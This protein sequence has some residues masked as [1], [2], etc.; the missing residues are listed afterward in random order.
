MTPAACLLVLLAAGPDAGVAG[1]VPLSPYEVEIS[2]AVA[3]V[4][5]VWPLP[6]ALVRAVIRTESAF[7]PRALSTAGAKGLMQLMPATA[8]KVG[9]DEKELFVPARNILAGVRLLAAL[10]KYYA[11]DVVSALVAYNA[12]PRPRAAAVPSNGETPAYVLRILQYWREYD[13]A[14]GG[15]P[16]P[17]SPASSAPPGTRR[18]RQQ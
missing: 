4:A 6:P 2:A 1:A 8:A 17:P 12:G 16:T 13:A 3:A 11:G 18:L 5:D 15:G 14:A 9:V 7:N 10:L